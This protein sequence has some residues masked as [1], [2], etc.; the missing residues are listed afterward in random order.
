[1]AKYAVKSIFLTLQGEG[2]NVGRLAVFCRFAG[3]NLWNGLE[4]DREDAI[5]RFCDTDFVGTN[6]DGGGRYSSTQELASA[7]L[8]NWPAPT[9]PF[10]V[11]TGGEPTL[12]LDA[13]LIEELHNAGAELAIET[14]GTNT[15]LEGLDWICVSPKA[16]AGLR[17][18]HGDELKIAWPQT[19]VDLDEMEL[20]DFAHRFLQPIDGPSLAANQAQ[21][22]SVCRERPIWRF[23]QQMH[24]L[25]GIP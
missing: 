3:C 18:C 11:L 10:I 4:R 20:L 24:K 1:M 25:I 5:C 14:N 19:G 16:G 9:P 17:Q 2:H 6:G 23:S 21:T 7:I 22:I 15:V 8:R 13:A 12:Q